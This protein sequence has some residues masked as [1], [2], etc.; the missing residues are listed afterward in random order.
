MK[1]KILTATARSE[2]SLLKSVGHKVKYCFDVR[3]PQMEHKLNVY[4]AQKMDFNFCVVMTCLQKHVCNCSHH[5]KI[6]LYKHS[7][8]HQ[9]LTFKTL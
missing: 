3:G 5:L 4:R 7:F 8:L 9:Q 1:D 2:Q 6:T